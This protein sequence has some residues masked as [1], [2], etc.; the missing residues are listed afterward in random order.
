MRRLAFVFRPGWL[1][2][3]LVVAAF[4]SLCFTVLAPWQLGEEQHDVSRERS[5]R[6]IAYR[7]SGPGDIGAIAG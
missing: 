6:S 7:R 2:L 1:A 4:A 5:D 3:A